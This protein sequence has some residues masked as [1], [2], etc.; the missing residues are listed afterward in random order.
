[1]QA[2]APSTH[3]HLCVELQQQACPDGSGAGVFVQLS[4]NTYP[5]Q[6]VFSDW[7]SDGAGATYVRY[8]RVYKDPHEVIDLA[9]R[10]VPLQSLKV[11]CITGFEQYPALE[12]ALCGKPLAET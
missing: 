12:A 9:Q 10:L 3:G 8:S 1:M 2:V 6:S 4:G 7:K 11:K 5:L